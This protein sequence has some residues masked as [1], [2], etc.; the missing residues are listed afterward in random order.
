MVLT[1]VK[2]N[3]VDVTSVLLSY[4]YERT[5]G[6]F[7]PEINL[8]FH[9][10][11]FNL[12]VVQTGMTLTVKRGFAS[13]TEDFVFSGYIEK[14]DVEGG[15]I[16]VTG[17]DKLWNMVRGEVTKIYTID[18]AEAGVISDIFTDL[19][20]TYAGLNADSGTVQDT[21]T[22]IVLNQFVCNHADVFERCK[23]LANIVD[24]QFYYRADTDKV[25]FEPEGFTL[26]PIVLTV[27]DNIIGIPKWE[28]DNSEM[29][30][31][32]TVAGAF[33]EVETTASGQ[34]GVTSG[35]ATTGITLAYEPISVKVYGDA[36]SPPTT[37]LTGGVPDSTESF[38]YSVDKGNKKILPPSGGSFTSSHYYQVNYSLNAPVSVNLYDQNSIDAYGEFQKTVT[39]TDIRGIADAESR[40]LNYLNK[41]KEPFIYSTLKI[42]LD[43]S[44]GLKAGQRVRIIDNKNVPSRDLLLVITAIRTRYPGDYD[45]IDVGDRPWR[46][47]EYQ[48]KTYEKLKR[49]EEKEFANTEI[50]NNL[51]SIDNNVNSPLILENFYKD[52]YTQTVS[53]TGSFILG[54]NS[55]DVLGTNLLGDAGTGAETLHWRA[56]GNNY[57]REDFGTTDFKDTTLMTATWTPGTGLV[58]GTGDDSSAH[59]H[60]NNDLTDD[61]TNSYDGTAVGSPSYSTGKL[62][63]GLVVDGN[64]GFYTS[65]SLTVKN[66]TQISISVWVKFSSLSGTQIIYHEPINASTSTRFSLR[67]SSGELLLSGRASDGDGLTTFVT[68]SGISLSTGAWYHI[69]GVYNA[70]GDS[71]IYV[72]GVEQATNDT[73]ANGA[74]T[75]TDPSAATRVCID[76]DGSN[77][78]N[79]VVDELSVFVGRVLQYYE[80]LY[81][82][83]AG[84]GRENPWEIAQS[85][86]I[87]YNNGTVS[88]AKMTVTGGTSDCDYYLSANASDFEEITSASTHTFTNTGTSLKWAVVG[89]NATITR[90]IVEDHH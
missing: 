31:N 47:S 51:V 25:Y 38:D 17:I 55:Y 46:I 87:D 6:N 70:N 80:V 4:N 81:A 66:Q 2:I 34:I 36:S 73:S 88:S 82:Y 10:N 18:G 5:Y 13:A 44:Y 59:Y 67:L 23:A 50:V 22:V 28:T 56:C 64:D 3:N 90:L 53:G 14:Y 60:L 79:G 75:N 77:G 16:D 26:N 48:A 33:Q 65:T 29:A 27:G 20:T 7:L 45:E 19:V 1:E 12:V 30:N 8:R 69:V 32:L 71:I 83:N 78:V 89:Y 43:S 39:F 61:S 35:F 52:V 49:Q 41:Y 72:N 54:N 85:N 21:G 63:E 37:L 40:G 42:K 9:K 11:V 57:Y 24:Y 86:S 62:N 76:N 74:F 68:T 15:V 58:F 84:S